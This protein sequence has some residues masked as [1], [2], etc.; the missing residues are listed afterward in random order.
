M[1]AA[2][3]AVS[4]AARRA[5]G[6]VAVTAVASKSQQISRP[7]LP[8]FEALPSRPLGRNIE[9]ITV[10][11]RLSRSAASMLPRCSVKLLTV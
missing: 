2:S 10:Y 7:L 4:W 9:P 5:A 3:G 1:A 8:L 6:L 11:S